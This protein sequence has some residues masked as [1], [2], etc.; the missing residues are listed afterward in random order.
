M[1]NQVGYANGSGGLQQVLTTT[2]T[3]GYTYT[4][5]VYIG[6]RSD[7]INATFGNGAIE[8]GYF[9]GTFTPLAS[10]SASPL[11]GQFNFVTGSY[12]ATAA[13]QGRTLAL[14]LSDTA[15]VQII[16]D[17]VELTASAIPEPAPI[18]CGSEWRRWESQSG[19]ADGGSG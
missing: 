18:A 5:S 6:Y 14:R 10:Q 11:R 19:E 12:Q 16:F 2:F 15:S 13:D 17:H 1:A 9:N 4:F 3:A 8:L 7:E